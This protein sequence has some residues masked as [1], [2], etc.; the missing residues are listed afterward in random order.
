MTNTINKLDLIAYVEH[1]TPQ[2]LYNIFSGPQKNFSQVY[3]MLSHK[4]KLDNF[5]KIE[6]LW[7]VFSDHSF[8]GLEIDLNIP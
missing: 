3:H 5:Q 6:I 8:I 7:H 1:R 2:L 4:A